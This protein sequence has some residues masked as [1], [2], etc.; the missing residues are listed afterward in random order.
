MQ[1]ACSCMQFA[2]MQVDASVFSFS[3]KIGV[4]TLHAFACTLHADCKHL[5]AVC[6]HAG[7]WAYLYVCQPLNE[8]LTT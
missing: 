7:K 1:F 3:S 4:Y 2:Y 6:I 5:H 8:H